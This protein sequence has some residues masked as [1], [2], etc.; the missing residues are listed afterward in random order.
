MIMPTGSRSALAGKSAWQKVTQ[1]A[2]FV[3]IGLLCAENCYILGVV[4]KHT[5]K[6][7]TK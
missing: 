1:W 7:G 3:K 4:E 5:R 2:F 6:D